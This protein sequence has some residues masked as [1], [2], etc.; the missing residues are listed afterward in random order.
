M[1]AAAL[2]QPSLIQ[3]RYLLSKDITWGDE[4]VENV[5]ISPDGFFVL[6][7]IKKRLVGFS[8]GLSGYA[9]GNYYDAANL[10][11]LESELE[12][13]QSA[14]VRIVHADFNWDAIDCEDNY[15]TTL[16][17]FYD[18]K[19]LV[20]PYMTLKWQDNFDDL[21]PIDF[22]L[23]GAETASVFALKWIN[24]IISYPNVVA[25]GLENELDIK[26]GAQNYTPA[27]AVS[28]IDMLYAIW[29]A[30][31]NIP[32]I[33]KLGRDE[34]DEFSTQIWDA[35]ISRTAIPSFDPYY[36]TAA[37]FTSQ[38]N[39]YREWCQTKG[40]NMQTWLS[41]F[42]TPDGTNMVATDLTKAMIDAALAENVA[43]LMIV[44][45][46][47]QHIA[48]ASFFDVNGDPVA[49]TL[50]ADEDFADYVTEWQAAL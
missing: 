15:D 32:I 25:V 4:S 7:G 48:G 43:V 36:P 26:I 28:Y 16:Q 24:K 14:G 50:V 27:A 49:G 3:T 31:T 46:N 30:Q 22:V 33:I 2:Y 19:M 34:W 35:L 45:A 39:F 11:I 47:M 37:Q 12:C 10:T 20:Y 41:E 1:R 29:K 18:Y 8:I 23:D 17:L 38:C 13:L 5:R 6:D 42:G 40:F 44:G 21:S 9:A